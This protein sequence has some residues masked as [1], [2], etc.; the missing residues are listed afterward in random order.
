MTVCPPPGRETKEIYLGRLRHYRFFHHNRRFWQLAWEGPPFR[1]KFDTRD[2]HR[3][4]HA[5]HNMPERGVAGGVRRSVWRGPEA[6]IV[7]KVDI[8]GGLAAIWL[9]A[10]RHADRKQ[11]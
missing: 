5:R 6:G 4:L 8:K 1:R 10:V 3:H 9:L 7:G 11:G 2:G